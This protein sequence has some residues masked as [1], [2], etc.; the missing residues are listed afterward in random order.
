MLTALLVLFSVTT[1]KESLTD[2][3]PNTLEGL[4]SKQP[5]LLPESAL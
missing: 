3:F 2:T 5:A 4:V 1:M